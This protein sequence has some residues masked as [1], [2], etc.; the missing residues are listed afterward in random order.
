VIDYEAEYNNRAKV[1]GHPA[2]MAG[3]A[4]DAAAFRAA[5]AGAELDLAYGPSARQALDIFWPGSGWDGQLA[6]FIHGGYWQGLDKSFFSHLAAGLLAHGVAVAVPS[7]DLCPQL[8]VGEITEQMRAACAF[9]HRRHGRN[10]LAIGHSAGGHLSAMLMAT[11]W[12]A[13]GL[14]S[15]LVPSALAISGLF[16][17]RPLVQTSMNAA[18]RL[19]EAEA[20]RLSPLFVPRPAGRI[21]AAVGGLEGP[22]FIGQSRRIAEAWGGT[23]D[24]LPDHDHFTVI[25]PLADPASLMVGS[26]LDL[27]P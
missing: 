13:R 19:D 16:D 27:L 6:L 1:P 21:H 4:R 8:T 2:V 18:L 5:C 22:E 10:M 26:A 24:V 15:G 25:A 23:W 3:W 11:D 17:L 20:R 7:Y 9:L 12:P 14:P